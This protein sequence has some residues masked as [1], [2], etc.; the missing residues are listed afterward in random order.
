MNTQEVV[1]MGGTGE[2][3]LRGILGS[4]EEVK[5]DRSNRKAVNAMS[6]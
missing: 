5:R 6:W 3:K 2:E 4:L 1:T